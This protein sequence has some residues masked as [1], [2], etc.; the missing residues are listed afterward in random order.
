M[1]ISSTEENLQKAVLS[2][3]TK[4]Y[5]F[6]L[7]STIAGPGLSGTSQ[8]PS[9][10]LAHSDA[11]V[12]LLAAE[13]RL[14]MCWGVVATSA[15]GIVHRMSIDHNSAVSTHLTIDFCALAPCAPASK[16]KLKAGAR[17][18]CGN[19]TVLCLHSPLVRRT[20]CILRSA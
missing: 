1:S 5:A 17:A 14:Q 10:L 6:V 18:P 19:Y 8:A 9:R 16:M 3:H 15:L 2:S 12:D 11:F 7:L 13:E 20:E 4:R